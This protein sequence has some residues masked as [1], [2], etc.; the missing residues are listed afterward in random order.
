MPSPA[1]KR[2]QEIQE[3]PLKMVGGNHFGRYP[4]ISQ[5]QTWN[6]IISDNGLVDYAGYKRYIE[7]LPNA[8]GRGIYSSKYS[9]LQ[10]VVIGAQFYTIDVNKIVTFRGSLAT[11][12][13]DVFMAENNNAEIAITDG[14]KIYIYNWLTSDYETSTHITPAPV[15]EFTIPAEIS[16]PGYISFQ[17]TRFIVANTTTNRWYL[18]DYN[19]GK[20]WY[21]TANFVGQLQSKPDTVQAVVPSPGGGNVVYVFGHNVIEQWQDV[22]A[23]LFPYQKASTFNV[24][25]GTVNASSIAA[26][27]DYVIWISRNEFAGAT[28]M[29]IENGR[30]TPISDDG[31]SYVLDNLTNPENCTGFLFR[32]DGHVIYQFTF[33]DDN[34]SYI[35]DLNTKEF[36]TVSD[37][38]LNYHIARNVVYFNNNYYF[39][40]LKGGNV[41]EFGTQYSNAD[42]GDGFV[43]QIPRIRVP[44]PIRLPSQRMFIIKSIGFTIENGRKNIITKTTIELTDGDALTTE[45]FVDITTESGDILSTEGNII[46]N[47]ELINAS[48]CVDLSLSRDGG[49]SWGNSWRLDMNETGRRQSRFIW[50]S[51]GQANDLTA[52]FRFNGF[53]RFV[54]FDGVIEIYQ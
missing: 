44:P 48:E 10:F 30:P 15:N 37:E 39:V 35:L 34:I 11:S 1:P 52:Q 43:Y 53:G 24:D 36:F 51:C 46:F 17:N 28:V 27:D 49:E 5:E 3:V 16:S 4:K 2:Q 32:Q 38:N 7:L 23:A 9:S 50:Q 6:M 13:G 29:M 12:S 18:S 25:Y 19:D 20:K 54:A 8:E 40:S 21:N 42:Y 26:L 33:I 41:Y 31:I 45:D 22:G 47:N 14:V